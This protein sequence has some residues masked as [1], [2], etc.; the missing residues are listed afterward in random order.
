ML[1]K[2]RFWVVL[3]GCEGLLL[4]NKGV[5]ESVTQELA[6]HSTPSTTARYY[7][8]ID[9]SKKREALDKIPAF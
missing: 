3:G 7:R 4:I 5:S 2:R 1:Q 9:D 8:Q 6:N